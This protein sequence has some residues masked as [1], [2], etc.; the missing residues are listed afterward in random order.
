MGI[1]WHVLL[2]VKVA[3]QN[4]RI[5]SEKFECLYSEDFVFD[6]IQLEFPKHYNQK[7]YH[8]NSGLLKTEL[9]SFYVDFVNHFQ[10][11]AINQ[12]YNIYS[13]IK[14]SKLIGPFLERFTSIEFGRNMD[15][16]MALLGDAEQENYFL[17]YDNL[18]CYVVYQGY[19]FPTEYNSSMGVISIM[20]SFEK[21]NVIPEETVM[22]HNFVNYI[23]E[24]MKDKYKISKYIFVAGY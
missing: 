2:P 14:D 20:T 9:Q 12:N 6:T 16:F 24:M 22:L 23:K 13:A 11:F 4:T 15:S 5:M 1:F 3:F 19:P 10:K 8:L 18:P 21:I 7:I 17:Y